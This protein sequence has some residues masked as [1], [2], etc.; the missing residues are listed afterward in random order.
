VEAGGDNAERVTRDVDGSRGTLTFLFFALP[1]VLMDTDE[2]L[3]IEILREAPAG[4]AGAR[5]GAARGRGE[6]EA[7]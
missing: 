6:A 5:A 4:G 1:G 2:L 3:G 7:G